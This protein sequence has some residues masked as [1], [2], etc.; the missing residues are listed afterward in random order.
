MT[1]VRVTVSEMPVWDG[2]LLPVLQVLQDGAVRQTRELQD[3]VA[4]HVGLSEPQ[5]T[6]VLGSGQLRY[7]S[8]IGWA[9]SSLHRAGAVER[10]KRGAYVITELGVH[11]LEEYPTNTSERDLLAIPTYAERGRAGS[12][13]VGCR[14]GRRGLQP[15]RA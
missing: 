7:R 9:M 5:R 12:Q 1:D 15:Q 10:P 2:F 11:L 8:R 13:L 4:S 3:L 14:S 6:E